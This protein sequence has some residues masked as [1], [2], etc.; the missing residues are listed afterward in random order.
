MKKIPMSWDWKS[1]RENMQT[2]MPSGFMQPRRYVPQTELMTSIISYIDN[3]IKHTTSSDLQRYNNNPALMVEQLLVNQIM[4]PYINM[5]KIDADEVMQL[6][7]MLKEDNDNSRF[8][9]NENRYEQ[10]IVEG[11]D[12]YVCPMMIS[13]IITSKCL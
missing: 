5:H 6:A 3:K 12:V 4:K 7:L 10:M 1:L 2:N 11:N 13:Q 9:N 8:I